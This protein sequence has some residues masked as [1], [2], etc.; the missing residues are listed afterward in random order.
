MFKFLWKTRFNPFRTIISSI[1]FQ[2]SIIAINI[3]G[4]STANRKLSNSESNS[5]TDKVEDILNDPDYVSL[6]DDLAFEM[7]VDNDVAKIIREMEYKKHT[8]VIS[9]TFIHLSQ[10]SF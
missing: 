6:Y 1:R 8:A 2:V 3:L 9:E 4:T 7:Y 10:L 5:T